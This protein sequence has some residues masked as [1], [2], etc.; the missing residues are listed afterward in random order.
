VLLPVHI[1]SNIEKRNYI[2]VVILAASV[3]SN[4]MTER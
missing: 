3:Q 4:K 1:D 2:Q